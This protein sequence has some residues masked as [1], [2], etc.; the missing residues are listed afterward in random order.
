MVGVGGGF[1]LFSKWNIEIKEALLH[2]H[3]KAEGPVASSGTK[4]SE[5]MCC[6]G[7]FLSLGVP[8]VNFLCHK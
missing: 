1:W 5:L 7:P 8:L 3:V 6:S 2:S 4:G